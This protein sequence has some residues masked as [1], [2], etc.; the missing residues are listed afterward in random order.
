[1]ERLNDIVNRS[2]MRRAQRYEQRGE[3]EKLQTGEQAPLQRPQ[4]PILPT[5]RAPQNEPQTNA[6]Q[7][8]P[9]A[10]P[11]GSTQKLQVPRR[12]APSV[13]PE[14]VQPEQTTQRTPRQYGAGNQEQRSPLSP[15]RLADY[16]AST[17][18]QYDQ[19]G[20]EI[21]RSVNPAYATPSQRVYYYTDD[22]TSAIESD[23]LPEDQF[24]EAFEE[25]E[26]VQQA[27]YHRKQDAEYE[28]PSQYSRNS[29]TG[30]V[31]DVM[32]TYQTYSYDIPSSELQSNRP[33]GYYL[34]PGIT[35][36]L[37]NVRTSDGTSH[38]PLARPIE[39]RQPEITQTGRVTQ[40]LN[41]PYGMVVART[42]RESTNRAIPGQ[43]HVTRQRVIRDP[44]HI[45]PDAPEV[46]VFISPV[47]KPICP[48]CRGVGYL[49][50][51]VPCGHPN[52]GKPIA[53]ECK[54]AERKA[55][56]R[57]QLRQMSNIDA[58]QE[59]TFSTF[60]PRLPGVK[61]AFEAAR[62]YA[63]KPDEGWLVLIGPNGCGKTHLAAA[64][65]NQC[66]ESGAVI[67]F[68]VVPDLLDH[69]RA[70]FAPTATEVY[71][72]LFSKMREAEVL[73]LDDL[74]AQQSS[75]WA[76][77][78]LFQ[79]LNYRYNERLPTVITANP[80]GMQGMDERI[81][82]RLGDIGLAETIHFN[83]AQDYRPKRGR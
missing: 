65:A 58:F 26:R 36:N 38:M 67:L 79:L 6:P 49:R 25:E 64:I 39:A 52:F 22:A 56:R 45:Q 70:A 24:E 50:V 33:N 71:D 19:R 10:T 47:A 28:A 13:R 61:E 42:T 78:K 82:S 2:A 16:G 17:Y 63:E 18:Q 44:V 9:Y 3:Q 5:R 32:G 29:G 69:L 12:Y 30:I 37:R 83:Y 66:L 57:E 46:G 53:C 72:Q 54:E 27:S 76:N 40:P 55:K 77:E 35:Q 20:Q 48:K 23:V 11:P 51:N 74:G 73:I 15:Q 1:M 75:P 14:P 62:N 43:E 80:K 34:K 60:N 59:S 7:R 31:A 41:Q 21:R 4:Q 68:A 8:N 81:R